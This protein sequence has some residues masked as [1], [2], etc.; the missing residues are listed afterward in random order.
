MNNF[1]ATISARH[2]KD[3][4]ISYRVMIRRKGIKPFITSFSSQEEA[5]SFIEKYEKLYVLDPE[6]FTYDFLRS[7]RIREF[8]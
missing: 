3:G 4:T 8:S 6:N 7:R 2:N 1:M 5:E